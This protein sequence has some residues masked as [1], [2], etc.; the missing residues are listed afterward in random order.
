[1]NGVKKMI[2]V[3]DAGEMSRRGTDA[4]RNSTSSVIGPYIKT[5]TLQLNIPQ[6]KDPYIP[7]HSSYSLSSRSQKY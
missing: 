4:D 6:L 7:Q 2:V 5:S 3:V 1:M